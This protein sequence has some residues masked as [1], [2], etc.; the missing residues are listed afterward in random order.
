V[1]LRPGFA[2]PGAISAYL[3]DLRWDD[4]ASCLTFEEK[5]REDPATRNAD[6]STSPTD[7]RS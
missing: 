5:N 3:M 4:A 1:C 2:S 6:G 7:A